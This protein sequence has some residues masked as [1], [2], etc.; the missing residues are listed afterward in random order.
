MGRSF[1]KKSLVVEI[2]LAEGDF[3]GGNTKTIEG[4][5]CEAVITKPGLP[6]KC[7]AQVKIW[8]L[9]YDDLAEL[10]TLAFEPMESARNLIS[11]SAGDEGGEKSRVFAGEIASAWA[12]FEA[13]PDVFLQIEAEAGFYPQRISAPPMSVNGEA[14]AADLI[15]K[16]AAEMGYDFRNRGVSASVRNAYFSGS[17]LEK[18]ATIADQ[19]GAELIIDDNE[20]IL[21]PAGGSRGDE[22]PLLRKDTGMIGYPTFNQ[23][24]IVCRCFYRKDLELGGL[25]KVESIVPRASGTWKITKLDYHLSAYQPGG[26]PWECQI[27]G[28][29]VG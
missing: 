24:G 7:G 29:N 22:V 17:P 19:V 2:I 4:L 23:D 3:G 26:G 16:Q 27:E 1:T 8:G 13:E 28:Q 18:A 11:I 25:I 21:I 20:I 12:N 5:A 6:E 15:A 10:T 14:P 9:P